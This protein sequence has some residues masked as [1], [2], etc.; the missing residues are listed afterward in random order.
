MASFGAGARVHPSCRLDAKKNTQ[1][2]DWM[3]KFAPSAGACRNTG[4][5]RSIV[6]VGVVAAL[7]DNNVHGEYYIK[8]AGLRSSLVVACARLA[9]LSYLTCRQATQGGSES[10]GTGDFQHHH[11]A[12]MLYSTRT[13]V[14][15]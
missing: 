3:G 12:E 4:D 5:R 15:Q 10:A 9:L 8:P 2:I 11:G 1:T 13:A 7:N 6:L 14:Q